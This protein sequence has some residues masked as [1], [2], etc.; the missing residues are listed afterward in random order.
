MC[1]SLSWLGP[2]PKVQDWRCDLCLESRV[3]EYGQGDPGKHDGP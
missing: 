3:S 1:V 2:L